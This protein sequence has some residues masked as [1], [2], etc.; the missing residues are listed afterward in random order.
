M[1][2]CL[3]PGKPANHD[4]QGILRRQR[5]LALQGLDFIRITAG[6]LQPIIYTSKITFMKCGICKKDFTAIRADAQFCSSNCRSQAY[7]IRLR[8]AARK[9]GTSEEEPDQEAVRSQKRTE[10]LTAATGTGKRPRVPMEQQVLSLAPPKAVGYRLV[11]GV[12]RVLNLPVMVPDN[13]AWTLMPFAAPSDLRLVSGQVY[14]IVWVDRHGEQV[15]PLELEPS[16][17]LHFFLGQPDSE[18]TVEQL[19]NRRHLQT[20]M[21]LRKQVQQLEDQLADAKKRRQQAIYAVRRAKRLARYELK[22]M[23]EAHRRDSISA[24]FD[25]V[26]P[27]LLAGGAGVLVDRIWAQRK[28]SAAASAAA[29][30]EEAQSGVPSRAD[31]SAPLDILAD[32]ERVHPLAISFSMLSASVIS[33]ESK[34]TAEELADLPTRKLWSLMGRWLEDADEDSAKTSPSSPMAAGWRRIQRVAVAASRLAQAAQAVLDAAHSKVAA[35]KPTGSAAVLLDEAQRLDAKLRGLIDQSN[36]TEAASSVDRGAVQRI[37][38]DIQELLRAHRPEP[39]DAL[40]QFVHDALNAI[41]LRLLASIKE[42]SKHQAGSESA[43]ADLGTTIVRALV[44]AVTKSLA[45]RRSVPQKTRTSSPSAPE[46]SATTEPSVQRHTASQESS[47]LDEPDQDVMP[48]AS[49]A[50][51]VLEAA[52]QALADYLRSS[53]VQNS[54]SQQY[55]APAS[56]AQEEPE[57]PTNAR[58][59]SHPG[60]SQLAPEQPIDSAGSIRPLDLELTGPSGSVQTDLSS[61]TERAVSSTV[62]SDE[63][64]AVPSNDVERRRPVGSSSTPEESIRTRSS[65]GRPP[66]RTRDRNRRNG[67]GRAKA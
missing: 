21:Q 3:K 38:E 59:F 12:D 8:L 53:S 46:E 17:A 18:I 20:V 19:E 64:V 40:G 66:K 9:E 51:A 65:P 13:G 30:V 47:D 55:V 31:S 15:R 11:L 48:I 41:R 56:G 23:K 10:L 34:P 6:Y 60:D 61:A 26:V 2:L 45:Q 27:L 50:P 37:A 52:T 36:P 5:Y 35:S 67:F 49:D 24:L 16:P 14:R 33:G 4:E 29:Q 43:S 22:L 42:K 7:R 1:Y 57:L 44:E 58:G 54:Q 63:R 28:A 32:S 62:P 39:N 25:K